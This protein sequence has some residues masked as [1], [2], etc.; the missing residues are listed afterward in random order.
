MLCRAF[1]TATSIDP[2]L[3][4]IDNILPKDVAARSYGSERAEKGGGYPDGKCRVLLSET[5]SGFDRL[6]EVMSDEAAC[7]K[8]NNAKHQTEACHGEEKSERNGVPGIND[9]HSCSARHYDQRAAPQ[10]VAE[11][12]DPHQPLMETV[13]VMLDDIGQQ[14]GQ[15]QDGTNSPQNFDK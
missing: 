14:H 12:P 2:D 13:H 5:L 11:I 8:L 10:I 7:G 3:D 9:I 4:R 1:Q 6:A 15:Q